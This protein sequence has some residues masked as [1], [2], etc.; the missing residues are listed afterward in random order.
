MTTSRQRN[1]K[2]STI[3]EFVL[4]GIPMIF[5]FI[6]IVEIARGMWTY[7]TLAYAVREGVR[8]AAMHGKGCASP[9][10]CQVT[11]GGITS[12]IQAAGIGLDSSAVTLTFTPASGSAS[13]DTMANQASSTTTWPPSS[14]NAAGQNVKISARYPFRTFLAIFWVG[15]GHPLNDTGV[16]YLPASSTAPIQF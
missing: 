3:L 2:G 6:S 14:A 16:F 11:I 9:N 4:V 7:H 1:K 13:T 15:D 10:T 8:Y 5:I 12:K